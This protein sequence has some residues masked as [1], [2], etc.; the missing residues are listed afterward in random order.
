MIDLM[1]KVH[2]PSISGSHN[3]NL[4]I[5]EKNHLYEKNVKNI[6]NDKKYQKKR[7]R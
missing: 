3:M 5:H 7:Y 4:Q 6:D 1:V 2:L